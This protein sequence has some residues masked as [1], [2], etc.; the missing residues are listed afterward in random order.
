MKLTWIDSKTPKSEHYNDVYFLPGSGNDESRNVFIEA[1]GLA[2]AL[3]DQNKAQ[4]SRKLIRVGELG[5]GTGLN[6]TT[7]VQTLREWRREAI[8]VK[9]ISFEKHPLTR[10]QLALFYQRWKD[11]F[12]LKDF[13][14]VSGW[15]TSGS[16]FL[17][18]NHDQTIQLEVFFGD[19]FERLDTLHEKID[20]WFFDGF[21]PNKNSDLWSKAI[22]QKIAL[23]SKPRITRF[24]TF[25]SASFVRR[26]LIE[27]G[28]F[29][30][31]TKGFGRKKE[32]LSGIYGGDSL[33]LAS[34]LEKWS[35]F[36]FSRANGAS[37]SVQPAPSIVVLGAGIAGA[38]LAYHLSR[39]EA[40][41]TV[42]DAGRHAGWGASG[43][44]LGLVSPLIRH[45]SD[46]LCQFVNRSFE[47]LRRYLSETQKRSSI[48]QS[49]G[50]IDFGRDDR[51]A[52]RLQ[53]VL[54]KF[55]EM[56]AYGGWVDQNE[57]KE[58]L[59]GLK[60]TGKRG[61]LLN[62]A[63]VVDP[64]KLCEALIEESQATLCY[65]KKVVAVKQTNNKQMPWLVEMSDGS[66]ILATDVIFACGSAVEEFLKGLYLRYQKGEVVE[67][68]F[69]DAFDS[70][71]LR[72]PNL[73]RKSYLLSNEGKNTWVL[74]A[75]HDSL[76]RESLFIQKT[77]TA[78]VN[79]AITPDPRLLH[80]LRDVWGVQTTDIHFCSVRQ[81]VRVNTAD[82][83]P[84]LGP[85]LTSTQMERLKLQERGEFSSNSQDSRR[86]G[87][88]L[89]TGLGSKGLTTGFYSAKLVADLIA[90]RVDLLDSPWIERCSLARFQKNHDTGLHLLNEA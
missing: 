72:G 71:K 13:E 53:T 56:K 47:V 48:I 18:S 23:L 61:V 1:S 80:Q 52:L 16:E 64:K 54:S 30:Q 66:S 50:L 21:S 2:S 11:T 26:N 82:H 78:E 79:Q 70:K 3:R 44:P 74:G 24:S 67:F 75:T 83:F 89:L 40:S 81:S 49:E 25:T 12:D 38:S 35:R 88:H 77:I 14:W 4:E 17:W 9:F 60:I 34:Q 22:F 76:Q 10:D 19:A 73:K 39:H 27:A 32:K 45:P 37:S 63:V 5:F 29:C 15:D 65:E 41:V 59:N 84:V 20:F 86:L 8:P 51:T 85:I 69:L 46:P 87:L 62:S 42:V 7:L 36:D 43:N 31:K 28:F 57:W 6:F 90:G 58:E 33:S 68:S 55:P